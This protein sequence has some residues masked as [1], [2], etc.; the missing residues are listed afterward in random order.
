[1]P[2]QESPYLEKKDISLQAL[3]AAAKSKVYVRNGTVVIFDENGE[4][5]G[6]RHR[7][8]FLFR[9]LVGFTGDSLGYERVLD[10]KVERQPGHK[11]N[12]KFTTTGTDTDGFTPFGDEW[13][14]GIL[15]IESKIIVCAGIAEGYRLHEA[16]GLPVACCVGEQKIAKLVK[17]MRPF[18]R[19]ADQIIAAVDNDKAGY[20]AALRAEAPYFMP[21]SDKD[22]SD[23]YQHQGGIEA[24][25]AETQSPIP[26]PSAE[27]REAEI[28]RL[29]GREP[30]AGEPAFDPLLMDDERYYRAQQVVEEVEPEGVPTELMLVESEADELGVSGLLRVA[31]DDR[32]EISGYQHF[33][34]MAEMLDVFVSEED[35]HDQWLLTNAESITLLAAMLDEGLE[36]AMKEPPEGLVTL[37]GRVF[38]AIKDGT[39]DQS[40]MPGGAPAII[41]LEEGKAGH[42]LT[43]QSGYDPTLRKICVE[44]DGKFD[45][46]T[47][48]WSFPANNDDALA[49]AIK[50]LADNPLRR[51]VFVLPDEDSE[52]RWMIGTPDRITTL[53]ATFA[54][55]AGLAP[56]VAPASVVDD[57][58]PDSVQEPEVALGGI[59]AALGEL[60]GVDE[61]DV[62]Y[63][64]PGDLPASARP[65]PESGAQREGEARARA[66]VAYED[67]KPHVL[68]R[69]PYN[70]HVVQACRKV[71]NKLDAE[72][73]KQPRA[74]FN[75]NESGAWQFPASTPKALAR[76][77]EGF[78]DMEKA[79]VVIDTPAGSIAATPENKVALMDAM[80]ATFD[81]YP[82]VEKREAPKDDVL[83]EGAAKD[84]LSPDAPS[85]AKTAP[86]APDKPSLKPEVGVKGIIHLVGRGDKREIVL[87]TEFDRQVVAACKRAKGMLDKTQPGKKKA[88]FNREDDKAWRF[89][90][91][92]DKAL[93]DT[94]AALCYEDLPQLMFHSPHGKATATPA[95]HVIVTDWF[96][97]EAAG[98]K[99]QEAGQERPR[100]P[101]QAPPVADDAPQAFAT[102]VMANK[103]GRNGLILDMDRFDKGLIDLCQHAGGY[104][105]C[106]ER[107]WH[108]PTATPRD[109]R[110]TLEMLCSEDKGRIDVKVPNGGTLTASPENCARIVR[111]CS[112]FNAESIR[113]DRFREKQQEAPAAA[114][115]EAGAPGR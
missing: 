111:R 103:A 86:D 81:S 98:A 97:Q 28:D 25:R 42:Q 50:A 88:T 109:L 19:R 102:V 63:D 6:E 59:E 29:M 10:Q 41:R 11:S 18:V 101:K 26:Q 14:K 32:R 8:A 39:L 51:M 104:F 94:I 55:A 110:E 76:I 43:L 17:L 83:Q 20:M 99:V 96:H 105:D 65:K 48:T 13:D 84:E 77:L 112:A 72:F 40:D 27:W 9:E 45:K 79:D 67:G 78:C 49:G 85:K 74:M 31:H 114:G 70:K 16:T 60:A 2:G 100:Q 87:K 71:K 56:A 64:E 34:T 66:K 5:A 24:V 54:V 89:P 115:R 30:N 107:L 68:L 38:S 33:K 82:A 113:V 53:Q 80:Q 91:A 12:D 58:E 73:P 22:F 106:S 75:K 90:V 57:P 52:P 7:G 47:K 95:N 1:M 23:V 3:Q 15:N 36:K 46:T 62:D 35:D 4:D 61:E 44:A 21:E 93:T 69:T 108:F 37:K 92:D